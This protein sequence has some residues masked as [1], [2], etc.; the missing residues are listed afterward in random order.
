M[1]VTN[2]LKKLNSTNSSNEKLEILKSVSG[3]TKRFFEVC[4]NPR[5][6]FGIKKRP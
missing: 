5:I 3:E 6:T 4:Y 1:L 2:E